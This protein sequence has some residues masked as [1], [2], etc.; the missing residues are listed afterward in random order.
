MTR[1][2]R[3]T[4]GA[5][6]RDNRNHNPPTNSRYQALTSDSWAQA[7]AKNPANAPVGVPG[8]ETQFDPGAAVEVTAGLA[9]GLRGEVVE[10][11]KI[12]FGNLPTY[13]VRFPLPL[14]LRV[15]RGDYLRR[16]A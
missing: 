16:A 5:R 3:V 6:T 14:G 15:I 9:A 1:K 4:D 2:T 10:L 13:A 11:S 8:P 12:F 7:G